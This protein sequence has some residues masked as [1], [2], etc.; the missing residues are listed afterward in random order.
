MLFKLAE[1]LA[2]RLSAI[3]QQPALGLGLRQDRALAGQVCRLTSPEPV[4]VTGSLASGL[5]SG[6]LIRV[7]VVFPPFAGVMWGVWLPVG[8]ARVCRDPIT[9]KF[10][11][12]VDEFANVVPG[13]SSGVVGCGACADGCVDAFHHIGVVTNQDNSFL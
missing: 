8:L 1:P 13:A 3:I 9:F 5:G 4:K 2:L 7:I 12:L 6:C 11:A 10:W